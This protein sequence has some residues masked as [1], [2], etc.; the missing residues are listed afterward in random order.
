MAAPT[1]STDSALRSGMRPARMEPTTV[2]TA[3]TPIST[4]AW[5]RR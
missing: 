4:E 2:P 3:A 1:G 5:S